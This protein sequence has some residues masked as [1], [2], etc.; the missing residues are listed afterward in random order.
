M[1]LSTELLAA[2]A[3]KPANVPKE[4]EAQELKHIPASDSEGRNQ[5]SKYVGQI[6]LSMWMGKHQE[7]LSFI[8]EELA[9]AEMERKEF[10][11]KLARWKLAYNAPL[12][13]SPKHFPIYNSSN[14][15]VPVIKEIVNT[16]AAQIVQATLTARPYWVLKDLAAEWK[17][18]IAILEEFL[19]IAAERELDYER[20]AIYWIIEA[21]KLGTSILEVSYDVDERK[22]YRYSEDGLR[23]YA[24]EVINHDGPLF[25]N[26]PLQKFWIRF[27]ETDLQRARWVAKELTYSE[28]ELREKARR[29]KFFGVD[30]VINHYRQNTDDVTEVEENTE[31]TVPSERR[32]YQIFEIWLTY[33]I[34][35]DGKN[36]E[37]LLYYHRDS[38]TFLSRQ[39]TPYWHGKRPF[40]KLGYFPKEHR[41]YDEGLAEM[42]EAVQEGISTKHN[43]R[44]DNAT[45]ANLKMIIKR[46]MVKGLQP[47]D[48]LYNGKI[49][50]VNDIWND[51]REFQMA[52]IYPSTVNEEMILR[53]YAE[54][55]SGY[56]DAVGGAAMPVSRTT[57]AA[58]L[59]LL[60]EQ[61]KRIDLTVRGVRKGQADA[62]RLVLELYHQFGLNG[63][64]IAWLGE[65]GRAVEVLFTLPRRVVEIGL[66]IKASSPTSVQNRQVKRENALALFNLI[67][68]MYEKIMPLAQML[69]PQQIGEI[70]HALVRSA[71]AYMSDVLETFESTDPE[72][73]LAGLAVLERVLPAPED[74]GGLES[75][76]R[77]AETSEI[78]SKVSRL[79]DLLR[80]VEGT[81]G[82]ATG[83]PSSNN[84]AR[85]TTPPQG[86]VGRSESS[87]LIGGESLYRSGGR[88]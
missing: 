63:K 34:D 56:N 23:F 30:R 81:R 17:P 88:S 12:P 52:E 60:Q 51:L 38:K 50:E 87:V 73:V 67:V 2:A 9:L 84:G 77:T 1:P 68:Q 31:K 78:I 61:A 62:I 75:F 3:E 82:G 16:I 39:F 53:Q 14:L 27:H 66:A 41:F 45:M 21:V 59:A 5:I 10:V 36:E 37:L 58:Q 25:S 40:V 32:D 22:I 71:H 64:G 85:R 15:T 83:F 48:P 20:A 46:K 42:L 57:A 86:S 18:F 6:P 4:F 49:I 55:V 70:A 47:G 33:D 35:G 7:I 80:E 28:W 11:E 65:R 26:V 72:E 76:R 79:E 19:D 74:F 13:T 44:S 69:A 24:K 43:Q 29:N 54:R 8:E